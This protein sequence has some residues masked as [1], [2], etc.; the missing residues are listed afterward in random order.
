L[1]LAE[2]DFYIKLLLPIVKECYRIGGVCSENTTLERK[3]REKPE[4]KAEKK[5]EKKPPHI[6]RR[7]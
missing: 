3:N 5:A 1:R 6:Q 2:L 4:K 7:L